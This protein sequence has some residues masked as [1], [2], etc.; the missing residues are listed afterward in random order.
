MYGDAPNDPGA[1]GT[2]QHATLTTW[3]GPAEPPA[4]C[5]RWLTTGILYQG[6]LLVDLQAPGVH[7]GRAG[8]VLGQRSTW[9]WNDSP[10]PSSVSACRNTQATCLEGVMTLPAHSLHARQHTRASLGIRST[11]PESIELGLEP[12]VEALL[13]PWQFPLEGLPLLLEDGD[14]GNAVLYV[15]SPQI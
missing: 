14:P 3:R 10:G 13:P 5:C 12:A 11:H 1:P 7:E 8:G 4:P 15:T 2:L 9:M 6:T